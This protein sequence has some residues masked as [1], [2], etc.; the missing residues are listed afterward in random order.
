MTKKLDGKVVIVIGATGGIGEPV[1]TDLAEAGVRLVIAARDEDKLKAL[2][3]KL[4]GQ[5]LVVPTDAG[6]PGEVEALFAEAKKAYSHIDAVLLS[7]GE[8]KQLSI[9]DSLRDAEDRLSEHYRG[10]WRTAFFPAFVAQKFFREQ[11]HGWIISISSH[12]AVR[13]ELKGNLTYGS[14]KAAVFQLMKSLWH[15]LKGT[16][17]RIN[18]LQ[19]GTVDT[20]GNAKFLDTP[21]KKKMAI[22]PSRISGWIMEHFFD[23]GEQTEADIQVK[24]ES[25]IEV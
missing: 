21:E 9:D 13:P 1:C 6:N 23:E 11:G 22:P 20:P 2:A 15:E 17:V 24:M 16:G 8:W 14:N 18:D 10:I 25:G 3:A 12:A 4:P 19:P 5:V 7:A